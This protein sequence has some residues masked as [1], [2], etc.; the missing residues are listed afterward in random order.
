MSMTGTPGVTVV[1]L[2]YNSAA[3][4]GACLESL[5][6]QTYKDFEVIVVD[7]DSV[8]DT[9][10]VVSG[11][12]AKLRLSVTRNGSR[13]IPRGRNIG[14][15]ESGRDYVAFLDSDDAAEPSWTRTIVDAF[16]DHPGTACL[17]GSLLPAYRT[18]AAH[19]IAL[20]DDAIRRLFGGHASISAGNSA[21]NRAVLPDAHFD[22]DFRFAEDL[23]LIS[24]LGDQPRWQYLDEMKVRHFSR[25][26]L[27]QYAKQMYRYGNMKQYFAYTTKSYRWIDFVPLVLILGGAVAS[28][29]TWTWWPVLLILPFSLLESLFVVVYQRCSPWVAVLTFP[30]WLIKNVAWSCGTVRGLMTLG[31]DGKTRQMLRS[32]RNGRSEARKMTSHGSAL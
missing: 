5:V 21:I 12:S 20:N 13:V 25:D 16:A 27:S 31:F 3:T 22:E 14:L 19:A 32:K 24:R 1:I 26:T 2:T 30:A 4:V 28:L 7:D 15:A 18:S 10:K 8:D 23:E 6:Q 11:Y 29:A 9:I 17:F